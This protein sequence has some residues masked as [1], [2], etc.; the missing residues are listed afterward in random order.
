MRETTRS[1]GLYL[2]LTGSLGLGGG[3]LGLLGTFRVGT[4]ISG[5]INGFAI[6][7]GAILLGSL[8][9]SAANFYIGWNLGRLLVEKP[10]IPLRF[11][12]ISM[13]LSICTFSIIGF[14]LNFYIWYQLKRLAKE[15]DVKLEQQTLE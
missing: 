8:A 6:L 9:I 14:L 2:M 13:V 11:A 12:M 4:S 1:L 7:M 10:M 15:A 3:L 5:S